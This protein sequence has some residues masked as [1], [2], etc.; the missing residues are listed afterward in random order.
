[1]NALNGY[2]KIKLLN[3]YHYLLQNILMNPKDKS[4]KADIERMILSNANI[5]KSEYILNRINN[6]HSELY[7]KT[8]VSNAMRRDLY[9]INERNPY[10]ETESV[11]ERV[12]IGIQQYL[13]SLYC[14]LLH[15]LNTSEGTKYC[16]NIKQ[17]CKSKKGDDQMV[18][19]RHLFG[20][21]F[22]YWQPDHPQF[23]KNKYPEIKHELLHNAL[24]PIDEKDFFCLYNRSKDY[25]LSTAGKQMNAKRVKNFS[26]VR[27]N[28][29]MSI[30]HVICLLLY[31]NYFDDFVGEYF[32]KKG[33][34]KASSEERFG[35]VRLRN[36]EISNFCKLLNEC[37]FCFGF[38][39]E[40]DYERL[41]YNINERISFRLMSIEW[42]IPIS[43][44]RI[45]STVP[46]S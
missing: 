29:T 19:Y 37:I 44:D 38:A 11:E 23:C 39:M 7:N 21:Y 34:I 15:P 14:A 17:Q 30:G 27:M 24:Y 31:C 43:A 32:V 10:I 8:K 35:K 46:R 12:E 36:N 4:S 13:D 6:K 42:N 28:Q 26:K 16:M 25:L 1:M 5:Y 45:Q 22:N 3:D 20:E 9:F 40:S 41:Y 33:C 2:D 18:D